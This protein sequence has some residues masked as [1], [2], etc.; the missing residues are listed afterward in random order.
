MRITGK[1]S[2]ASLVT[3]ALG[4]AW[5]IALLG[6]VLSVALLVLSPLLSGPAEV[7]AGWL[8]G[9]TR[10]KIPVSFT[11]DTA[12]HAVTAPSL[13]IGDAQIQDAHG[14]LRFATAPRGA[15]FFGNLGV[16]VVMFALGVWVIGQLRA[17][18]RTVRDGQPFVAANAAR[19]RW[20]ACG[21]IAGEHARAALVYF[22]NDYARSHFVAEG[23][24]FDARMELNLFAIMAGLIILVIAEV[25][26]AGTRLDEEQSL[27]V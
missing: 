20:I 17:V 6:L 2:V 22:E 19:L 25:F 11:V 15:F 13:G 12:A 7:S 4:A 24:R 23:L 21:V 18:F 14:S 1:R 16:L 5:A 10:M 26:S 8:S 3:A 9:G 27:T